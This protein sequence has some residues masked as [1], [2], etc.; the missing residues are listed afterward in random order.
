MPRIWPVFVSFD[1]T[2]HFGSG[3]YYSKFTSSFLSCRYRYVTGV[4]VDVRYFKFSHRLRSYCKEFQELNL[5]LNNELVLGKYVGFE[6]GTIFAKN[7]LGSD[8]AK[9]CGSL[10]TQIKICRVQHCTKLCRPQ[11]TAGH[12]TTLC[13]V[14]YFRIRHYIM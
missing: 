14:P 3:S 12:G 2:F 7:A 6:S 5:I 9:R 4:S 13:K 8:E 10:W 1:P 11:S